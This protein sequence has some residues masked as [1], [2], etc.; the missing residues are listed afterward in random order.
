M[1]QCWPLIERELRTQSRLARTHW[2]R[3]AGAVG[4]LLGTAS[5]LIDRIP[6]PSP[7]WVF[8]T[9]SINGLPVVGPPAELGRLDRWA[10]AFDGFEN[11]GNLLLAPMN[12]LVL[13]AIWLLVPFL[14]ADCLSWE[15]RQGTLGIL[16]LTPLR[17]VDVVFA[18]FVV[19]GWQA[20]WVYLAG[21][22]ILMIPLMIGGVTPIDALYVILMNTSAIL[23]GLSAGLVASS[24]WDGP[25]AVLIGA[26]GCTVATAFVLA[27]V[28][29][30]T[31]GAIAG[32]TA[33]LAGSFYVGTTEMWRELVQSCSS[34]FDLLRDPWNRMFWLGQTSVTGPEKLIRPAAG[35]VAAVATTVGA[36]R[37]STSRVRKAI[38][39]RHLPKPS[40]DSSSLEVLARR[41]NSWTARFRRSSLAYFQTRHPF[42]WVELR[43]WRGHV[44]PWLSVLIVF[45]WEASRTSGLGGWG[46][47]SFL[48]GPVWALSAIVALAAA[49]CLYAERVSGSP[50]FLLTVPRGASR[51]LLGKYVGLGMQ[52]LPAFILLVVTE[53]AMSNG[54]WDEN[55][56]W[57]TAIGFFGTILIAV[58]GRIGFATTAGAFLGLHI[59]SLASACA[60]TLIAMSLMAGLARSLALPLTGA[61]DFS[62]ASAPLALAGFFEILVSLFLG[63]LS[64]H[65]LHRR[66]PIRS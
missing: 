48:S 23:M 24:L 41:P 40:S 33:G 35:L 47:D 53:T 8:T 11:Q 45:P 1:R 56:D 22:P 36:L 13:V 37:F 64:Y 46:I 3:W 32:A 19:H 44:I 4:L 21:L 18:K 38:Q 26:A 65:T 59:R 43:T 5:Y 7:A 34:A 17:A 16:L 52:V 15:R 9:L 42:L 20:V 31:Q 6:S 63:F 60:L 2:I 57:L 58:L 27:A 62:I 12:S 30:I 39:E 49:S 55:R 66:S 54:V 25:R 29:A 50:E 28:S 10:Q 61:R 51:L 14:T